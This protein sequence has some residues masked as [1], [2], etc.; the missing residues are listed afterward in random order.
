M[1]LLIETPKTVALKERSLSQ[2][3]QM[4][5]AAARPPEAYGA[6]LR[7]RLLRVWRT[8]TVRLVD[9]SAMLRVDIRF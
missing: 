8:T 5:H 6:A 7:N 9:S 3:P 1:I 2:G 4:V